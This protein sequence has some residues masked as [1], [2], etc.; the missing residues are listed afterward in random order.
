VAAFEIDLDAAIAHAVSVPE[1]EDLTSFP[2]L[3]EDIAIVVDADVPAAIVLST[4]RAAG[5][6]LLA[7]AEVF[8]V[9]SGEQVPEG[10]V[11]L[12]I[13]LTF[14]AT[15]RTLTDEDIVPLREQIVAR[16]AAELQGELRG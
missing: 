8:D 13:A 5:G 2:E 1:Y 11:S 4:I 3:H 12:A 14:R 7:R 6:R 9:Y 15:D 16:L 10:R